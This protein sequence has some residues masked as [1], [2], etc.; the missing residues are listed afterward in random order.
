MEII[1]SMLASLELTLRLQ[2]EPKSRKSVRTWGELFRLRI[3]V[4]VLS[5]VGAVKQCNLHCTVN[6]F[7]LPLYM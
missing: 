2:N 1:L 4:L 6:Y 3:C 5:F 7:L